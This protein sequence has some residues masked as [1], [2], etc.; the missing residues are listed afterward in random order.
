[1]KSSTLQTR[2]RPSTVSSSARSFCRLASAASDDERISTTG[3][4]GI[5]TAGLFTP[6]DF[7]SLYPF[8]VHH[9][10]DRQS[11]VD[12]GAVD[13]ARF[14]RFCDARPVEA[15]LAPGDVLY[16]PQYWWHHIENLDDECVSLNFWY[17]DNEKGQVVLPLKEGQVLAMRRNIEKLVAGKAGD[18]HAREVLSQILEPDPAPLVKEIRDT[19]KQLLLHVMPEKAIDGWLRDLVLGRYL[20]APAAAGDVI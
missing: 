11:Q 2:T 20:D 1:M 3:V 9:P 18:E 4:V 5:A 10:N 15:V 19:I 17:R 16:I 13:E 7:V 12:F 14:P 6:G 8:P